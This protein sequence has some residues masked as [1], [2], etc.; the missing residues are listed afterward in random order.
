MAKKLTIHISGGLGWQLILK[1]VHS[2]LVAPLK[3]PSFDQ[4]KVL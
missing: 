1:W 4:V 3:L 2:H